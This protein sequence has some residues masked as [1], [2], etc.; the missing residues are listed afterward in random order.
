MRRYHGS[1]NNPYLFFMEKTIRM[2][3]IRRHIM[4]GKN[5]MYDHIAKCLN[6]IESEIKKID[7]KTMDQ[8]STCIKSFLNLKSN[9]QYQPKKNENLKS[10]LESSKKNNV[11]TWH[12]FQQG[13]TRVLLIRNRKQ[14]LD[15]VNG[16]LRHLNTKLKQIQISDGPMEDLC[17]LTERLQS[18]INNFTSHLNQ[19]EVKKFRQLVTHLKSIHQKQTPLASSTNTHDALSPEVDDSITPAPLKQVLDESN[20]YFSEQDAL[21]ASHDDNKQ[22][23][24]PHLTLDQSS[25]ENQEP[26]ST[27]HKKYQ[28]IALGIGL[29][30]LSVFFLALEI[31][32][33]LTIILIIAACLILFSDKIPSMKT[34]MPLNDPSTNTSD[35]IKPRQSTLVLMKTG[36][37]KNQSTKSKTF[38]KTDTNESN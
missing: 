9:Y 38:D 32:L 4:L 30:L 8:A 34:H 14:L 31:A 37:S 35:S 17:K 7:D 29:A 22:I 26:N 3:I 18:Q 23:S 33:P 2:T 1:E 6:H 5:S 25:Q 19:N 11:Q 36:T 12:L 27:A 28:K 20:E 10:W 16:I 24:S 15:Q 13:R 21:T